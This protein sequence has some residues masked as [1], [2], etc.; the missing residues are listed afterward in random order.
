MLNLSN[1]LLDKLVD[2]VVEKKVEV[3]INVMPDCMEIKIEPWKPYELK[4]PY[5]K[6]DKNVRF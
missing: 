5:G 6:D 1:E 3:D 2:M 4:C